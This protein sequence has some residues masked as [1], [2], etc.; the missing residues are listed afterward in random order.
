MVTGLLLFKGHSRDLTRMF[1]VTRDAKVQ[2]IAVETN[3]LLL[4]LEK[5]CTY[6]V[7]NTY[8]RLINN[9]LI[10]SEVILLL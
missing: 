10:F 2:H 3:R 8:I 1:R 5:V 6:I 4:R 7:C 9:L